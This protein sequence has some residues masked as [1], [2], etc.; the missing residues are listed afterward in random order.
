M[1]IVIIVLLLSLSNILFGQNTK[2]VSGV[3]NDEPLISVLTTIEGQ[4]GVSFY[5]KKEWIDSLNFNGKFNSANLDSA[6]K[7]IL[8]DQ[9]VQYYRN[10]NEIIITNDLKIIE[11]PEI[12]NYATSTQRSETSLPKGLIFAGDYEEPANTNIK[13]IQIGKRSSVFLNEESTIAGYVI[14]KDSGKPILGALV[15]TSEPLRT[16]TTDESGF[17]SL[18]LP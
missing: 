14:N 16:A 9:G 11:S 1:R 3:F 2:K 18:T 8:L 10:G 12:G 15:Y 6:L 17:Y 13:V 7:L 5:F 4:T